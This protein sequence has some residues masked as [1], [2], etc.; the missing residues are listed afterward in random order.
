LKPLHKAIPF[1]VRYD[2]LLYE[3]AALVDAIRYGKLR[4]AKI[5]A[6]ALSQALAGL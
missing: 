2:P 1:A 6:N 3:L 5:A 4:E